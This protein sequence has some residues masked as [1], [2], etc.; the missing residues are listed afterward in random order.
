MAPPGRTVVPVQPD[1]DSALEVEA[2]V[3]VE[4]AD[5]SGSVPQANGT[6]TKSPAMSAWTMKRVTDLCGQSCD[7]MINPSIER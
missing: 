6:M 3:E 7:V 1:D 4:V 2:E 5:G